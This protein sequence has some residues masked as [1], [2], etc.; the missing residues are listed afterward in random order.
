LTRRRGAALRSDETNWAIKYL[1]ENPRPIRKDDFRELVAQRIPP[2]RAV[3]KYFAEL[4]D[5]QSRRDPELPPLTV[6]P[7]AE[8]I[9]TGAG[10]LAQQTLAHMV[11]SGHMLLVKEGEVEW[12]IPL[13]WEGEMP[14]D[15]G[16]PQRE[17]EGVEGA[18]SS[19]HPSEAAQDDDEAS[20]DA[21]ATAGVTRRPFDVARRENERL[22][23]LVESRD[24]TFVR[25][26]VGLPMAT[27]VRVIDGSEALPV[28]TSRR[29]EYV[30]HPDGSALL[31]RATTWPEEELG[32]LG[33]ST[34]QAERPTPKPTPPKTFE[35]VRLNDFV[36]RQT[37]YADVG[38]DDGARLPKGTVATADH[39]LP[40]AGL[41]E[42]L[43][44]SLLGRADREALTQ[45]P[46]SP[47]EPPEAPSGGSGT[48][49]EV[50][51]AVKELE[52]RI[53]VLERLVH[54]QASTI[55]TLAAGMA[56]IRELLV[57][58]CGWSWDERSNDPS[59]TP[60]TAVALYRVVERRNKGMGVTDVCAEH[61]RIA[62]G[63]GLI[64]QPLMHQS[65]HMLWPLERHP[66][67][68]QDPS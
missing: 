57:P 28:S 21:T 53:G 65:P 23:L 10:R 12:Y 4:T 58:R 19:P 62:N 11:T 49:E 16:G 24:V 17:P 38:P 7:E 13:G 33:R 9:T 1:E 52:T 29:L 47:Q 66:G 25:L 32:T 20:E 41:H 44:R 6:K 51:G 60:C 2:G 3:R 5:R 54:N 39:L 30:G 18:D 64:T 14:S 46:P 22:R 27:G 61:A 56:T 48:P 40:F 26:P 45:P 15:G 67:S 55:A 37:K 63:R 35:P 68:P 34:E 36:V 42:E 8:Q 43:A 31:T 50:S 59:P